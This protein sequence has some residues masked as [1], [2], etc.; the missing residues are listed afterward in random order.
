MPGIERCNL[1][2]RINSREKNQRGKSTLLEKEQPQWQGQLQVLHYKARVIN[3]TGIWKRVH[4]EWK[5]NEILDGLFYIW[6][7][8]KQ[9]N[10]TENLLYELWVSPSFSLSFSFIISKLRI[11]LVRINNAHWRSVP[12]RIWK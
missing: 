8:V 12:F 11:T 6:W 7:V 9:Y 10:V 4:S 5:L 3:P 2:W 1:L